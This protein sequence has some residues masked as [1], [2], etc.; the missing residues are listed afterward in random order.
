IDYKNSQF[1]TLRNAE[2][3]AQSVHDVLLKHYGYKDANV[4]LLL[5]SK[6]T[7]EAIRSNLGGDLLADR[8]RVKED[9]CVLVFL[10]GH[11][12]RLPF[13]NKQ[14]GVFSPF[15]ARMQDQ[16][17]VYDSTLRF[18]EDVVELLTL[19]PARH[20]L[21]ILNCCHS[22]EVFAARFPQSAVD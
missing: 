12:H 21:L 22:G 10:A 6:A 15:D 3:D 4:K 2:K 11:G 8:S 18:D 17:P 9:D 1:R 16:S 14:V 13:L 7:R 5:G 19:C 20:K